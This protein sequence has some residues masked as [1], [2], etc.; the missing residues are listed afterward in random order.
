MIF[1]IKQVN[2]RYPIKGVMHV[3]AF[4]G[5]EL[6]SYRGLGL[7][8]TMMFEPQP[9]LYNLVQDRLILNETI[10]NVAL[11]SEQCEKEMYVSWRAGGIQYGC[12]ASSSLLKPKKHLTEHGDVLFP[13]NDKITVTVD[14]LDNYH[15]I[16]YNFLNIDVQGYELEV[17]KGA[18][19]TLPF[20]DAM[21]LEVN[22]D[23]VYEGCPM[24]EDLD[25]FL[26]DFGFT[27]IATAWQSESWGDAVYARN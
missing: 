12:G 8:N 3:G 27:R 19:A 24:V 7:D 14:V 22:R 17:L 4:A 25:K 26:H 21:I 6:R 2:E 1:D 11:G 18:V 23:E 13:D 15:T 5:E 10:H 16:D 20:I 9:K